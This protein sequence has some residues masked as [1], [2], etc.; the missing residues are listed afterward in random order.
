MDPASVL[1]VI[2]FAFQS[3]KGCLQAFELFYTAQHIGADGD[4]LRAFLEFERFKLLQWADKVGVGADHF[5]PKLNMNWQMVKLLLEQ[6]HVLL[7]SAE[8]L[9]KRYSLDIC[10][11]IV[12]DG[13]GV[14]PTVDTSVARL[15][16][17]LKP[18]FYTLASAVIQASNG[19]VKRLRWAVRDK[20]KL[21]GFIDEVRKI[22]GDLYHLL[23]QAEKESVNAEY[24]DLM[25]GI[26]S[27]SPNTESVGQIIEVVNHERSLDGSSQEVQAAATLKQ[28]RLLMGA[29]IRDDEA[30]QQSA[31]TE[32]RAIMPKL[33]KLKRS[34]KPWDGKPLKWEGLDFADYNGKQVLLQWKTV[35]PSEW[36]KYEDPMKCLAVLLMSM[37]HESFRSLGCI[38]YCPMQD[39]GVH[40]IAYEMPDNTTNWEFKSLK[41]LISTLPFVSLARR[42][43]LA[44][45]IAETLLQLHTAGWMHKNLRSDNIIFLAP[46]GSDDKTF[47]SSKP[48]VVGYDFARPDTAEAAQKYTQLLPQTDLEAELYRHPRARGV[49]REAY[50]KRFDLYA[51]ACVMVELVTWKPLLEVHCENTQKSLRDDLSK[52]QTLKEAVELPSLQ[53]LVGEMEA[54]GYLEHFAGPGVV[55]VIRRCASLEKAKEGEEALLTEQTVIVE[56][57]AACRV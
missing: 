30:K 34:L 20:D 27:L 36:A 24:T 6:L 14:S 45:A 54:V 18:R 52:A 25:R 5:Q 51:L 43:E 11:E 32:V 38:G 1:S 26:I 49:N 13:Q 50:Q 57:L 44:L 17:K 8:R 33:R 9:K 15:I 21:N 42:L 7:T 16:N 47:L 48:Y 55:H 56:K 39:K 10:I 31:S 23:E 22:T 3:F 28:V 41:K 4:R 53:D 37:T 35:E 40:G 29:E 12:Q 2:T 46:R 19:P